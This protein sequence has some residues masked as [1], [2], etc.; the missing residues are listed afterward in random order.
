MG[1][2][3][4]MAGK[5]SPNN[6]NGDLVR[7]DSN[8]KSRKVELLKI[9]QGKLISRRFLFTTPVFEGEQQARKLIGTFSHFSPIS[10]NV[11]IPPSAKYAVFGSDSESPTSF[12]VIS[13]QDGKRR[14]TEPIPVFSDYIGWNPQGDTVL[15]IVS[16]IYQGNK[17]SFA[18]KPFWLFVIHP[19][20]GAV[21]V[22]KQIANEFFCYAYWSR[23][24]K[25]IVLITRN[26]QHEQYSV[27]SSPQYP[28]DKRKAYQVHVAPTP[29]PLHLSQ[30]ERIPFNALDTLLGPAFRPLQEFM[31]K[32][33]D[34]GWKYGYVE[35]SHSLAP[36]G[37][38][39]FGLGRDFAPWRRTHRDT[40]EPHAAYGVSVPAGRSSVQRKRLETFHYIHSRSRQ[41]SPVWSSGEQF[42]HYLASMGSDGLWWVWFHPFTGDQLVLPLWYDPFVDLDDY[43][44]NPVLRRLIADLMTKNEEAKDAF[45]LLK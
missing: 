7:L 8:N 12:T 21:R 19:A 35:K 15:L 30:P 14:S 33:E 1:D 20:S 3:T 6:I 32:E 41:E 2:E 28:W 26:E 34:E 31:W 27:T 40:F 17:D 36:S 9:R 37:R 38:K 18:E 29:A 24:G 11:Y 45:V 13:V 43:T 39:A 42:V 44:T 16:G 10:K 4:M 25:S 23:N 22:I 5:I